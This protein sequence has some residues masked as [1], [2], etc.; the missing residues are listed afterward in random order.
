MNWSTPPSVP[1][2]QLVAQADIGEGAAHHHLVIAAP[3][4]IAD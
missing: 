2:H 4:A 1:V 3:C